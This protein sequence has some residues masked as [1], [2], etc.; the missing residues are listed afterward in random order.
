MEFKQSN[1]ETMTDALATSRVA[2]PRGRV[3]SPERMLDNIKFH[4]MDCGSHIEA[5]FLCVHRDD[6][7][8]HGLD[9]DM[10]EC[11]TPDIAVRVLGVIA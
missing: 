7:E 8:T 6:S 2:Y 11:D 4:C 10:C 3:V 5:E 9:L 1:T